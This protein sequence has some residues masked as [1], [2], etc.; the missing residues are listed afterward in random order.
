MKRTISVTLCTV[1]FAGAA[2]FLHAQQS[3]I[4]GTIE[5]QAKA[6]IAIPDFRGS[7]QAAGLMNTFNATL[8]SE[9]QNSG[10]FRMVPKSLMPVQI[11]QQPSDFRTVATPG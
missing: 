10:L 11:P 3:E 4:Q 1:A 6:A 8:F 9:I 2:F 5:K 7:G